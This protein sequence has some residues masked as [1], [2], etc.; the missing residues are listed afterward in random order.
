MSRKS[1]KRAT[2]LFSVDPSNPPS[3]KDVSHFP[4]SQS[5][6]QSYDRGVK[7]W[8]NLQNAITAPKSLQCP[9]LNSWTNEREIRNLFRS[10]FKEECRGD[11]ML[12]MLDKT[13]NRARPSGSWQNICDDVWTDTSTG[14][15][16]KTYEHYEQKTRE[17]LENQAQL[18]PGFVYQN[19]FSGVSRTIVADHNYGRLDPGD[20]TPPEQWPK[21]PN[22]WA[23]VAFASWST[24]CAQQKVPTAALSFVV[25][26]VCENDATT[27]VG[28]ELY[29]NDPRMDPKQDIMFL[30]YEPTEA[31]FYAL[32]GVPTAG[33]AAKLITQFA[34]A[35]AVRGNEDDRTQVTSVK[36]IRTV[37]MTW[38]HTMGYAD[39]AAIL[40]D[41]D[42]PNGF[43]DPKLP[44]S[45]D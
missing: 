16:K 44:A 37:A 8:K 28:R 9:N 42:P 15:S 35:F 41:T 13:E 20:G 19:W 25:A 43:I 39:T 34:N 23:Q 30:D 32:L 31:E 12:G 6:R 1:Q 10:M 5:F 29:N 36:S 45:K 11:G 33:G 38:H 2:S 24:V 7:Y 22:D 26:V 17:G 14:T 18:R 21:A 27:A 4:R 40:E 3:S